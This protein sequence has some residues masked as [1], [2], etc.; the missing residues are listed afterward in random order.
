MTT[1]REATER[2]GLVFLAATPD[3]E[4]ASR[5]ELIHGPKE[6]KHYNRA[7]Y[8]ALARAVLKVL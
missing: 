5:T 2:T 1:L 7:G 4:D 8:E 6:W 3:L